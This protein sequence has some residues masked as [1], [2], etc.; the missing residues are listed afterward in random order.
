[1]SQ[2]YC[3][4][5]GAP[6]KEGV[7]FCTKCGNP[8]YSTLNR[9]DQPQDNLSKKQRKPFVTSPL[10]YIA[11][12]ILFFTYVVVADFLSE[13]RES[14]IILIFAGVFFAASLIFSIIRILYH[15]KIGDHFVFEILSIVFMVLSFIFVFISYLYNKQYFFFITGF[16]CSLFFIIFSIVSLATHRPKKKSNPK[17]I[18]QK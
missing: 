1:M 3:T 4:K 10:L 5:C 6:L 14:F 13:M 15:S 9:E 18:K 17:E 16:G 8:V 11:S 7:K 2:K 12:I